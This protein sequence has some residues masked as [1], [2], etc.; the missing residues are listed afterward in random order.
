MT[1]GTFA[2]AWKGMGLWKWPA[3]TM[4]VIWAGLVPFLGPVPPTWQNHGTQTDDNITLTLETRGRM[5]AGHSIDLRLT[6]NANADR[7]IFVGFEGEPNE[8]SA[9]TLNG[10]ELQTRVD[11][12]VPDNGPLTITV[13]M[14]TDEGRERV[15]RW[16]LG[17]P[18]PL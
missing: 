12:S 8:V 4:L 6:A 3:I 14:V 10:Q 16:H 13:R 7:E 18:Q 9:L 2:T 17:I 5:R 1:K 11:L 15:F